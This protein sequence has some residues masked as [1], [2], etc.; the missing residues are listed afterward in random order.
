M[1]D[2]FSRALVV[3]LLFSFAIT[4][5][6][7][8]LSGMGVNMSQVELFTSNSGQSVQE[9]GEN[10][11][12]NFGQQNSLSLFDLGALVAFSGT[13]IIDLFLNFV[14]AI[15]NMVN[16]LVS[17][18]FLFF[19]VDPQLQTDLKQYIYVG[20]TAAYIIGVLIMLTNTRTGQRV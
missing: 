8:S 10:I 14:T 11:N 3:Q 1:V 20:L 5:L 16:I 17:A 9:I 6:V 15:P 12:N 7:Y 2:Y 13:F 19:P 18:F 4:I